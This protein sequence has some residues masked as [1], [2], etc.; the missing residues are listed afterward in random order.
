MQKLGEIQ[1]ESVTCTLLLQAF[2]VNGRK[3]SLV[4]LLRGSEPD[5]TWEAD[6]LP[7]TDCEELPSRGVWCVLTRPA[8]THSHDGPRLTYPCLMKTVGTL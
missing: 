5:C 8:P 6:S 2:R 4:L 1:A 7:V 3:P